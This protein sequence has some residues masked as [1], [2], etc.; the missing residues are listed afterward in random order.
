MESPK[1]KRVSYAKAGVLMVDQVKPAIFKG[2]A[3]RF[4]LSEG[5]GIK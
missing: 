5:K 4:G 1:W 2:T 3:M